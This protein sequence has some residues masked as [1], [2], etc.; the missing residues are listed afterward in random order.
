MIDDL[1]YIS[2]AHQRRLF[3]EV[4]AGAWGKIYPNAEALE[5]RYQQSIIEL[6]AHNGYGE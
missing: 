5:S 1:I 2:Y 6:L 4:A 3:P